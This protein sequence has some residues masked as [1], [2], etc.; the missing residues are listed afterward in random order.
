VAGRIGREPYYSGCRWRTRRVLVA[1]NDFVVHRSR[2]R[3]CTPGRSCG[4]Q[5]IFS[6][7][8]SYPS[9]SP[10]QDEWIERS[11]TFHQ[12]N[13]FRDNSYV[14]RWRF[15]ARDQ[16]RVLGFRAWRS[17]PYRQDRGST[18]RGPR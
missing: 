2:I 12:G 9:W 14:G 6:N 4:L 10:Y 18:L 17:A 13:V 7:W 5:G 1:H 11:I 16:S 3:R 15:M 8:G